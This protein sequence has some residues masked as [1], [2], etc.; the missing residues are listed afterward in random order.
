M[1][2]K[3]NEELYQAAKSD[4]IEA[5]RSC[6]DQGAEIDASA[7][8]CTASFN[9]RENIVEFLLKHGAD[10]NVRNEVNCT[11]IMCASEQSR[12]AVAETLMEAG[13][14]PYLLGKNKNAFDWA[15]TE[16]IKRLLHNK[17]AQRTSNGNVINL[18]YTMGALHIEDIYNFEL[19]E[20]ISCIRGKNNDQI[21]SALRQG[22]DQIQALPALRTAFNMHVKY[23][24]KI[25]EKSVFPDKKRQLAQLKPAR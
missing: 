22:F 10:V 1:T 25:P 7:A 23:G 9:G 21:Q 8:L 15:E 16:K 12:Y 24:G 20:R 2:N 19:L 5:V 3:L 11:P 4:D 14:D 17:Y 6:L 13:A 18:N